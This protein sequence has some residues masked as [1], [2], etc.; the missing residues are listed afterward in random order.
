MRWGALGFYAACV[1]RA[2]SGW[3]GKVS[4]WAGTLSMLIGV[5]LLLVEVPPFVPELASQAEPAFFLGAF[6]LTLV[7]RLLL[8]PYW[9][10]R[11]ES[12]RREALETAAQPSLVVRL[13]DPPALTSVS[14]G[15]ST[16]E[17]LAGTRQT[18]INRW[19]MDVV[20]LAC[21]NEGNTEAE[22]CRARLLSALRLKDDGCEDLGVIEAISLPWDKQNHEGSLVSDIPA[23]ETKRIWLGGVRPR[24][25]LW[26]FREIKSLPLDYQR[27]LGEPGTYRVLIQIDARN[28]PPQQIALEII[29]AE[30]PAVQNAIQRGSIDVRVL[31]QA[32]PRLAP[33][34]WRCLAMPIPGVE[35]DR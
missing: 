18:V 29:T 8:A 6:S 16:T 20:A 34:A 30:G 23:S 21:T 27:L 9:L 15:G 22:G 35:D 10:F 14:L 7:V 26:I 11:E 17:S 31:A 32:S 33:E 28:V 12:A 4:G 19:E 24:G 25:H 13:P 2:F 5:A 3:F 1:R